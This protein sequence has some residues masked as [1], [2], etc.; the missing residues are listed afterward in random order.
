[1]LQRAQ[2]AR[3]YERYLKQYPD[4]FERT[5]LARY[6]MAEIARSDGNAARHLALMKEVFQTEQA[7]GKARTER[8]RTMGALAALELAQPTFEAYRKIA[9]VEPLA[10]QLKAKKAKMEEVLKAYAVAADYG[11]A[12]A[13]TAATFHTAALYQDFGKALMTSQRPKKLSKLE[14]EQYNVML[15]EQ[16]FPFEEKAIELHET[17]ARHAA[18][19]LY[20]KWVQGSFKA[21]A[22][23]R[24]V[25]YGKNERSEGAVDAIR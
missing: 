5:V 1:V 11:V 23:L 9:L 8:T 16:A 22:E 3:V 18:E 4:P 10:K 17:N 12:E 19:G 14:L 7:G 20:D 13:T 2:A 24:P 15:E 6:R 21:L 25:R